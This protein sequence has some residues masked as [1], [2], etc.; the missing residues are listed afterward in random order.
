MPK[1]TVTDPITDQEIAFAHL[2]MS[3]TRNDRS[4]AEAAGLNPDTA[5]YTKAKPRVRAYMDEHRAAVEEKLVNQESEGLR[6]LNFGRDQILTRL[7]ELANLSPEATRNTMTG[8]IKA[9]SMIV[10]IEGL[11]PSGTIKDR[12]PSP[13]AGTQPAAP[14]VKPQNYNP[15]WSRETQHQPV[16]EAPRDPI[17]ATKTRPPSPQAPPPEPNSQPAPNFNPF[18]N[19]ER[20]NRVLAA[21][22]YAFGAVLNHPSY[23]MLSFA[24]ET[25]FSGQLRWSR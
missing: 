7:W 8:Q 17:N 25:G 6:N 19:P 1:S 10:A 24:P 22:D 13:S 11:I 3:G 21:T 2:I 20:P 5:A 16:G 18:I 4:A 9:L 12:R 14:P 23:R 15:E